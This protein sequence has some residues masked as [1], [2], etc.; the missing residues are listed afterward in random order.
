MESLFTINS[1]HPPARV[2]RKRQFFHRSGS[3]KF[4]LGVSLC[5]ARARIPRKHDQHFPKRSTSTRASRASR[6]AF[7]GGRLVVAH[8][9]VRWARLQIPAVSHGGSYRRQITW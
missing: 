2:L 6:C 9:G 8:V 5:V 1:L 3:A 7:L 4:V